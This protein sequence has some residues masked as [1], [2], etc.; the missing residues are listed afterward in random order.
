M[1]LGSKPP[2][3]DQVLIEKES[4]KEYLLEKI[5]SQYSIEDI[6]VNFTLRKYKYQNKWCYDIEINGGKGCFSG[7][8]ITEALLSLKNHKVWREI[9][10]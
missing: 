2:R 8:T 6:P 3:P 1:L 5:A 4:R 9:N 7:S 10:G